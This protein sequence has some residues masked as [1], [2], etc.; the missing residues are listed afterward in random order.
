[1]F[2]FVENMTMLVEFRRQ[3]RVRYKLNYILYPR[4]AYRGIQCTWT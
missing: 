1:M 3:V 2:K 4:P